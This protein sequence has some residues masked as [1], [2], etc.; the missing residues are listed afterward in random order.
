MLSYTSFAAFWGSNGNA[1]DPK[2]LAARKAFMAGANVN[3]ARVAE[4]HTAFHCQ[5]SPEPFP[6]LLTPGE[7]QLVNS[8]AQELLALALRIKVFAREAN[9]QGQPLL[10]LAL[11]RAQMHVEET[12][13]LV[14]A[15][16]QQ[17]LEKVLA[18]LTD[19][20]YVTTGTFLTYGLQ[21][22]REPAA[23]AVHNANMDKLGPDGRPIIDGSGRVVKPAGWQKAD[24]A[25]VLASVTE[26]G[27]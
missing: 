9:E 14:E 13:E 18:E 11:V 21:A 27:V 22:A 6:I 24:I 10:G 26:G 12:G 16:A 17:D 19:V 5:V 25:G 8:I 20:D 1:A 3:L 7:A 15:M 23:R 4:F 2:T